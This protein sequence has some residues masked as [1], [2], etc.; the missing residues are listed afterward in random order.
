MRT[1]WIPPNGVSNVLACS[2][3]ARLRPNRWSSKKFPRRTDDRQRLSNWQCPNFKSNSKTLVDP[4]T[5]PRPILYDD[6]IG[7]PVRRFPNESFISIVDLLDGS[8]EP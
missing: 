5:L 4:S 7:E 8:E 1:L 3:A 2:I 6:F